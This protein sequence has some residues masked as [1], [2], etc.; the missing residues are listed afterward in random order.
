M[1][2]CG[3]SA[4]HFPAYIFIILTTVYCVVNFLEIQMQ[5]LS[6][7]PI[8]YKWSESI[9]ACFFFFCV[10]SLFAYFYRCSYIWKKKETQII[11]HHTITTSK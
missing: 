4:K 8:A 6:H 9:V 7:A 3:S 11:S 1:L 5:N 2:M 10:F